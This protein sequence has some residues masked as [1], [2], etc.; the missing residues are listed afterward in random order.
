MN[1]FE[2]LFDSLNQAGVRYVLVGGLAV[3]LHGHARMTADVDLVV[4][5]APDEAAKTIKALVSLGFKP[6][7]PVDPEGFADPKMRQSWVAEKGMMVFT[8]FDP[9]N[10]MRVVDLFVTQPLPFQEL[11]AGSEV[12][13]LAT[14]SVRVASI[15]DLIRIKRAAGRP[16]DIEDIEALE[17]ILRRKSDS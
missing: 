14:T 8:M 13:P 1:S 9:A 15:Q 3:V 11:W 16:R 7:P 12:L 5:L 4:D 2:S 6:R 10:P 17:A